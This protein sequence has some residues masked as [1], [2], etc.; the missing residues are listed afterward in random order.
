MTIHLTTFTAAAIAL[1]TL[2]ASAQQLTG[3]Y[4]AQGLN[5]DGSAYSGTVELAENGTTVALTWMVGGQNYAGQGTRDGR[6][7][8]VNWGAVA[9]VIYVVMPD[10]SLHGT[11][12]NGR[13]LEKLT[14][15]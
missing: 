7:L 3:S 2:A 8:T 14:P 11:W 5:A 9:P 4:T 12:D 13:A 10:Q 15:R 1:S 6:I